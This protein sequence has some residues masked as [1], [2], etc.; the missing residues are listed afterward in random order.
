[1]TTATLQ[2]IGE[3]LSEVD[4]PGTF[5]AKRTRPVD[6]L[7]LEVKGV[8]RLRFP[9]PRSQAKQLCQIGRPAR[10]GQ[11]EKT[12][13]DR[14]VRDTWE[15]PKSRVKIDRRRWKRTL[16]PVLEQLSADLGTP[17]GFR[18]KAEL[19]AMLVYA[20]GQFFLPHQD[21]EKDDGM[22]GTLVVTLPSS[23]KGG[24]LVVEHQGESATYRGSKKY[25]SF[26]AFYA[27]C[28]HEV[29]P[30]KEG[31]RVVLTYNLMLE[32]NG[33][34]A[35]AGQ[36]ETPPTTVDALADSLREHFETPL[37]PRWQWPKDAPLREPPNRLVYLLDH[38]YTERGLSWERLKGYDAARSAALRAA[39]ECCDCELVLA[40]A[41]VHEIWSCDEPGWNDYRYRR[42]RRWQRDEDDDWYEEDPPVDDPDDVEL[43]ELVDS[44]ISLTRWIAPSKTKAAPI[45]TEVGDDEVCS[46][47][48]SSALAPYASE[49][50]GYTGNEGSTMDRWYRRA[51]MVL[52]PCERAFA[53][54]A[55]ASPAW[56]LGSLRKQ[57]RARQ[58]SEARA[59]ATSLLPFWDDV[60]PHEQRRRFF[61]QALAVAEGLDAPELATSLLK[62]FR[63]TALTPG[64]ASA[65]VALVKRY[66]EGWT[67]S[68]LSEWAG[69]RVRIGDRDPLDW[70]RSL[71]RLCEALCAADEAL[72]TRCAKLLLQDRWDFLRKMIGEVHFEL[73]RIRDEAMAT[74]A[75]PIL[76]ILESAEIIAA[77]DLWDEA[78]AF[79]CTDEN[80][81]LLPCL[82]KML[83]IAA[84][85]ASKKRA[86]PRFN[87]IRRHC[88]RMLGAR[89]DLPARDEDDW[90][91]DLLGNCRCELCA[92][93]RAFLADPAKQQLE[94]PLAK[95]GRKHVHREIDAYELPVRHE[96]RRSGSP[97][98]LVLS[99]TK[100][101]F[102]REARERRSWQ[103]DFDWLTR[104]SK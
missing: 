69:D 44:E 13:L 87:A 98:T 31:Y 6:D 97:Y 91:L 36:A 2:Q 74:L 77:E 20:P 59:M 92:E 43:E 27:D 28:R 9:V 26:V 42:D 14:C 88:I 10:Y 68:L 72:G 60:A 8:G 19:H 103:S 17:A 7:H 52:W 89:L 21:S 70:L 34:A 102:E 41:E 76:G 94:W 65:F 3:L 29:R 30:V 71:P 81:P 90:S 83:R 61:D 73:P 47:T 23:S 15:I 99:K 93:L 16:L 12:L 84:A 78:V 64:R 4:S 11:R 100:A 54:R 1:M 55:E 79:F 104:P 95:P 82:V 66:G 80:E 101:L 45:V 57:I 75:R 53:V 46:T 35:D 96:T 62:P 56:A 39:A 24:A 5:S 50:Q 86:T 51:A 49:Y 85:G 58:L 40:L 22:I 25:L 67:H 48:P 37:P 32:G 18:L 33:A 38:Q 63:V